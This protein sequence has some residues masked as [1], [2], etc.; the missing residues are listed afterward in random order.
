MNKCLRLSLVL[1]VLILALGSHRGNAM[2]SACSLRCGVPAT[3]YDGCIDESDNWTTCFD[4]LC[5]ACEPSCPA[6]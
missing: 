4:Y 1:A 6:W 2:P 3:C 5:G